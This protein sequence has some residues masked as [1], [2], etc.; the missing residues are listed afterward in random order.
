MFEVQATPSPRCP[1]RIPVRS[2]VRIRNVVSLACSAARCSSATRRGA[3]PTVD[4]IVARN[5]A[6]KGGVEKLRAVDVGQDDRPRQGPGRRDADHQLGEASQHD[7]AG[8]HQRR[9]DVRRRLRRHDR[10]GK[11]IRSSARRRAR[12][13]GRRRTDAPGRRRLR[14]AAARLQGEGHARSSSSRPSRAGRQRCTGCGSPRRTARSRRS[15]S[16]PRPCSNRRR[17]CRWSRAGGRRS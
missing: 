7:A 3:A 2:D 8:E 5:L 11:S 4:E 17:S 9:A 15:T 10:S 12:S 13:P 6:A 14:H 16:T 1:R